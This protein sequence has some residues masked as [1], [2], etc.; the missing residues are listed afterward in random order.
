MKNKLLVTYQDRLLIFFV[1]GILGGT[2]IANL[3]SG[4]IK[5]QIGYFDTLFLSEQALTMEEKKQMWYYVL[6]QR[7]L[8]MLGAWL[9]SLT[10]FSAAGFYSL[11]A[12]V[13]GSIGVVLSVITVQKGLMGLI[14]Y[15][16]TILPHGLFYIPIWLILA[17]WAGE[18]KHPVRI[19]AILLLTVLLVMGTAGEAWLSPI[20]VSL[21]T[22]I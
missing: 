17:S 7:S 18:D 1:A 20:I 8:E 5:Q 2:I 11:A 16:G 22:K 12:L 3:L 15:L 6:R 13:G 9:L 14:F 19:P 4:D 21:F 10:V